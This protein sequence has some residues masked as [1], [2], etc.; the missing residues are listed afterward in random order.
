V[1]TTLPPFTPGLE[2]RPGEPPLLRA[3]RAG[4]P[5][6]WTAARREDLLT[7]VTDRGC[8]LVRG[9]GLRDAAGLAGVRDALEL[10]PVADREPFAPRADLGRGVH[11]ATPWPPRQ[12]M[13]A[14]HELSYAAEFPRLML[15]GCLRAPQEGGATCV[16]DSAAVLEA[17]PPWLTGR[18]AREGWLLSRAYTGEVGTSVAEAFGT[19]DP[20]AVE[21]Y[22]RANGIRWSW[23]PD[24]T[25]RT[26][27]RR[28]AVA[29]HPVTGRSSWF[30][31]I[32][33][34]SEWT[35]DPDVR[36]F[37]LDEYGPDGLPFTTRFGNGAPVSEDVVEAIAEACGAATV[38]TPWQDGDLLI[39]DNVR[40]AHGREPYTGARDVAVAMAGPLHPADVDP[41]GE[42]APS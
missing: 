28:R 4:D 33:F 23:R 18:F 16:T 30:N 10:Q 8:L 1:S 12:P 3:D 19:D 7:A 20:A 29:R 2:T 35:T 11:A 32:A 27:Q 41:R 39:V 14:H 17:L 31:Q 26:W 25:L 22:C 34:L 36:G 13:C 15:F 38:S 37:L 40:C 21:A 42:E 24:G 6:A 9:L 5:G